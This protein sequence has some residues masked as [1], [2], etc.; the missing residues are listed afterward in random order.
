MSDYYP[1]FQAG[2]AVFYSGEKFKSELVSKD[3]KPYKGWIHAPV[4]NQP[5]AYVV[6]FPE[7]KEGDFILA[8]ANLN[9]ARPAKSERHDG[10]EIQPRR[11]R[12]GEEEEAAK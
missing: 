11:S 12:K 9:K 7:L 8:A 1:I 5:G 3:G 10:P 4:L 6:E 2:D